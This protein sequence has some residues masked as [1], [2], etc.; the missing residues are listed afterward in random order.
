MLLY[1]SYTLFTPRTPNI[2]KFLQE[3]PILQKQENL[4]VYY[5]TLYLK[6]NF[7]KLFFTFTNFYTLLRVQTKILTNFQQTP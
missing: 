1:I 6:K 3:T 4:Q 2:S 7:Y 5:K